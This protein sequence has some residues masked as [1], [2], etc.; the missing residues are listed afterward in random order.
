MVFEARM[1]GSDDL[2]AVVSAI[3]TVV[4]EATFTAGPE[5]I[6]F[7]GMDP[8]HVAL[9]DIEWPGSAFEKYECDKEVNFGVRIDEFAKIIKR[10]EK[11]DDIQLGLGDGTLEIRVGRNRKYTVRLIESEA[12]ETPIPK[13]DFE[14]KVVISSPKFDRILGDVGVVSDYLT[15]HVSEQGGEFSGK[16]DV[17]EVSVAIDKEDESTKEVTCSK[18]SSGT[19]SLEYLNPVIKAVGG[20]APDITCEFTNAKPV[21]IEFVVANIGRIHFYLAPR[22]ES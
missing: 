22:V 21:R 9:I 7:R 11:K 10:A 15:I 2:K 13:I 8:S 12:S 6:R 3:A 4:E 14:A 1:G 18:E 5:G 17:G 19:Y 16:G 20:T